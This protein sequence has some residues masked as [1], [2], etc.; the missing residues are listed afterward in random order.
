M[1][2]ETVKQRKENPRYLIHSSSWPYWKQ[3]RRM[4]EEA[5][6]VPCINYNKNIKREA[7][8]D[9]LWMINISK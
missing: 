6:W 3:Q 8:A 2:Q 1:A 5:I 7:L 9:I 4:K